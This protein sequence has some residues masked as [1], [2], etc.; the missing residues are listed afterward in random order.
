[1]K[2]LAS[3]ATES[4]LPPKPCAI[5]IAGAGVLLGRYSDVSIDTPGAVVIDR[6]IIDSAFALMGIS[7][8]V[9][10]A[11][12]AIILKNFTPLR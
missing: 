11:Q 2:Y 12:A 3:V 9:K 5:K 4:L 7:A 10:R 6:V 8:K 1:V